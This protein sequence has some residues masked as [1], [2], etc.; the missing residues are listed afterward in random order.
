LRLFDLHSH[1]GTR[2]GYVLRTEEQLAQQRR[3]WNS[4]PAYVTEDEMAAYLRAQEV[5]TI[6][7]FGFTKSL[8]IDEVKPYH[9]YALEVQAKHADVIFGNW[10]QID[11]RTGQAGA[12]EFRR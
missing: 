5:R 4:D 8:S 10:L 2:R 7:D 9:D 1:W 6:L 11:P 12:D 3:T